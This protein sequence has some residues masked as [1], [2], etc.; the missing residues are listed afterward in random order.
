[1]IS[2]TSGGTEWMLFIVHP[3]KASPTTDGTN[4]TDK[5]GLG[6]GSSYTG[7]LSNQQR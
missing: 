5:Q 1:M 7:K 6:F 3:E 4:D 2:A